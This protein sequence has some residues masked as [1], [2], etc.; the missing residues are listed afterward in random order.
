MLSHYRRL[1]ATPGSPAMVL[2]GLIARFPTGMVGVAA[3]FM[4]TGA[5]G[6]YGLAGALSATVLLVVAVAGPQLSR[7]VDR[8]GQARIAVPAQIAAFTGATVLLLCLQLHAP[9]WTLFVGAACS[10]VGPNIGAL[11]R[12]RW[13]VLLDGDES[14]L[15]SA[16]SFEAVVDEV[17]FVLGPLAATVL[18]TAVFSWAGYLAAELL[19]LGGVL[20]FC[21]QRRT[22][23]PV[24]PAG[25]SGRGSAL[26]SPGLR[27]VSGVLFAMGAMFGVNEITTVGFADAHGH[28]AA[29]SLVI[30]C[31]ALGSMLSGLAF[32]VWKPRG[33]PSRRLVLLLLLM[34]AAL[35]PLPF[36]DS[37]PQVAGV[38]LVAGLATAPTTVTAVG[39]VRGLV[40]AEKLTEGFSWAVTGLLLGASTGAAAGGWAVQHL[41]AGAGYRLPAAAAAT[42]LLIALSGIR[43]LRPAAGGTAAAEPTPRPEPSEA[44]GKAAHVQ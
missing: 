15:H 44:S 2:T 39:L 41:G 16:Y 5:R 38:L 35:T 43:L 20:A 34:S 21:A 23:P 6:S 24:A 11:V 33:S 10:G 37:L 1:F 27:V 42:A 12:A 36:L 9:T 31:Y 26:A 22:E 28:K 19:F 40:P 32:G 25:P 14:A 7:L 17:C 3:V 30:G 18:A 4:V 29:A 13:P 8:H